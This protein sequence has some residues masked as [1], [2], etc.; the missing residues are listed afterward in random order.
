MDLA[1]AKNATDNVFP[2]DGQVKPEIRY[3]W[4]ATEKWISPVDQSEVTTIQTY[5]GLRFEVSS[6]LYKFERKI[7]DGSTKLELIL[8]WLQN[9]IKPY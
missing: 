8:G 7:T 4:L 5:E 6:K 2:Q 9:Q 3:L 1:K